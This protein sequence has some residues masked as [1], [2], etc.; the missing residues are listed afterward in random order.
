MYFLAEG[1]I[2]L[3][4]PEPYFRRA[5]HGIL[6]V[7]GAGILPAHNMHKIEVSVSR[8]YFHNGAFP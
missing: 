6:K 1:G 2:T 7:W 5:T 4:K 3:N 8:P